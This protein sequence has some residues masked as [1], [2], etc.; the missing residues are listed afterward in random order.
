MVGLPGSGKSTIASEIV[1][2]ARAEGHDTI[3]HSTDS[4]FIVNGKYVFDREKLG[5]YHKLNQEAFKKSV[6]DRI[7]TIIVDNTNLVPRDRRAYTRYANGGK[8]RVVYV[9][10]GDFDEG[11]AMQCF[12]STTHGVPLETINRMAKKA[13]IPGE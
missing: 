1:N 3:I 11:A 9:V 12:T 5:Y 10:V 13:D 2:Q 8:Y 6:R 4:F 7:H